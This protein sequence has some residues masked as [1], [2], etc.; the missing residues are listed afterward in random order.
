MLAWCLELPEHGKLFIVTVHHDGGGRSRR[1]N[2]VNVIVARFDVRFGG[3]GPRLPSLARR[4]W[5]S[6]QGNMR[7]G[8][9]GRGEVDVWHSQRRWG[10]SIR[11]P[12]GA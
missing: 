5:V 11:R 8:S 3:E 7:G 9:V 10:G 6:R 12:H 4:R 2:D 1:V